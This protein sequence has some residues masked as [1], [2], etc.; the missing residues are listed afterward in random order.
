MCLCSKLSNVSQ[1]GRYHNKLFKT[2]AEKRGLLISQGK[3]I[4]WSVTTPSPDFILVVRNHGIEKPLDINRDG[5]KLDLAGL[6]GIMGG[7]N[8]NGGTD[9]MKVM[10]YKKPKCSTRKYQ[11]PVCENS[12]RATK[13]INVLCLDCMVEYEKV[14]K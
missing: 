13:D 2:E 1:N 11:C 5:E 14:E 4:G 9:G 6:L 8:G 3:Y 10:G 12:F 7:L